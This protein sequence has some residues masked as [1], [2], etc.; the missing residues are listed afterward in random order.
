MKPHKK[1]YARLP[2]VQSPHVVRRRQFEAASH[3]TRLGPARLGAWLQ[4]AASPG[5]WFDRVRRFGLYGRHTRYFPIS[6]R[7][8]T[9]RNVIAVLEQAGVVL[10]QPNWAFGNHPTIRGLTR[11]SGVRDVWWRLVI[12][13]LFV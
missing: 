7:A 2:S 9:F 10:A 8:I 12:E 5:G 1:F 11:S 6:G 3:H 13:L 4:R